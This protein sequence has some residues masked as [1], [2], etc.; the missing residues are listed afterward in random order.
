MLFFCFTHT[1]QSLHFQGFETTTVTVSTAILMLAMHPEVQDK[2]YEEIVN[3]LP[4]DQSTLTA[5]IIYKL[6]YTDWLVKESLR[7]FPTIPL[8][9]RITRQDMKIGRNSLKHFHYLRKQLPDFCP[10]SGG[11]NIPINTEFIVSIYDLHRNPSIWG[12]NA[13]KFDLN[14]FLPENVARRHQH[15]FI[16]F[17]FGSRN[18]VGKIVSFICNALH[19]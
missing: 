3:I 11:H 19:R 16:P 14:N 12:P 9:T 7:L 4:D 17:A 15:S 2:V 8:I 10:S 1:I 6:N 5:D 13:H 18:C